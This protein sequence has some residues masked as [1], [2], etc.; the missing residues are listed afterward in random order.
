MS[1]ARRVHFVPKP[2]WPHSDEL[3][4]LRTFC[5]H[6]RQCE[7]CFV[8]DSV[9]AV[10]CGLCGKGRRLS[11][12]LREYLCYHTGEVRSVFEWPSA[13]IVED[14]FKAARLF[15]QFDNAR[16]R[17]AEA[18][19]TQITQTRLRWDQPRPLTL[20]PVISSV[21]RTDNDEELILH[22]KVPTF[23]IPVKLITSNAR[24]R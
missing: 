23:T 7:Q 21:S 14:H 1:H 17:A 2:R 24:S 6:V 19:K 4:L 3:Y 12:D 22:V 20:Q 18:R 11:S 16:Y 9:S 10:Q 8:I 5:R 15:L 13:V